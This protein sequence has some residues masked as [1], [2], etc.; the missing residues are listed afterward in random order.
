MSKGKD[1]IEE[2]E[3]FVERYETWCIMATWNKGYHWI[4][5]RH[6]SFLALSLSL[7]WQ[8]KK[9]DAFRST[10][11]KWMATT[12]SNSTNT[13]H[14]K[15]NTTY[16][17]YYRYI[18]YIQ[19]D[20]QATEEAKVEE[21]KERER[22]KITKTRMNNLLMDTVVHRFGWN[23]FFFCSFFLSIFSSLW[24]V[25]VSL[26]LTWL[27]IIFLSLSLSVFFSASSSFLAFLSAWPIS[28][29]PNKYVIYI[30][31][32]E[33][34]WE[35]PVFFSF[36]CSHI[37]NFLVVNCDPFIFSGDGAGVVGDESE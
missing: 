30:Y 37:P 19:K 11:A 21:S 1:S 27:S 15:D 16:Y 17:Y 2:E 10:T 20:T 3:E 6:F 31:K 9:T 28:I 14:T 13:M 4:D 26:L 8:R 34:S 5:L 24:S 36:R 32:Y 18:K 25:V 22:E 29:E 35:Q 7:F 12:H 23:N 33:N